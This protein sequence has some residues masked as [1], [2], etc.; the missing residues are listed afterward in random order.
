VTNSISG[1]LGNFTSKYFAVIIVIT[2][3]VTAFFTMA[4]FSLEANTTAESMNSDT[5]LYRAWQRYEDNFRPST[6]GIPVVLEAKDGNILNVEEFREIANAMNMVGEDELVKPMMIEYFDTTQ[7]VNRTILNV[8]PVEVEFVMKPNSAYGYEIG[9]HNSNHQG[10]SLANATDTD[11]NFVLDALFAHVESDGTE[12]YREI[13]SFELEKVNGQ[14]QAPV[15]M[16]FIAVDRSILEQNYT[17]DYEEKD[18]KF[19]EEF[20]L[21]VMN[22]LKS[23]IKSCNVYGVGVGV[24]DEIEREIEESGPFTMFVFIIIIIILAVTFKNNMKSFLAAAIGL[25]LIVLWM[26]GSARILYLA[27]TQF[28]AFLPILIMA[29]GV[30]YAIHSMKRFDEELV[31][32]KTPREAI[33]GSVSKLSGTLALAMITTFV[34]FISNIFSTIPALKDWGIE[35]GLAIIWTLI[36]MGLFVPA[37]RL[38]FEKGVNRDK[39]YLSTINPNK[40]EK[41]KTNRLGAGLSNLTFSS[42]RHPS[43]VIIALIILVVPLGYGAYNL[44]SEFEL[45]EFFNPE[46]DFIVG[47]DI[48]TEHFPEGGEPNIILIE[49]DVADPT[50]VEAVKISRERFDSRGYATFYSMDID[51]LIQNFTENL[52][53]NNMVRGNNITIIDNNNDNIPDQKSVIEAIY[54]HAATYGLFGFVN[55][56]VTQYTRPDY[57]IEVLHYNE[58]EG[59]FDKTIMYVGVAGSGSLENIK[60]GMDNIEKDTKV[61]EDTGKAEAIVTGSGPIRYEQLTAISN[62]M[63]NSI[64]IS[65]VLCFIILL[66]IFRKPGFAI[67]AILPVILIAIWLYGIMHFTGYHLNIV[68]ATIGAM[69]IGVGV[70]YSIHV[71]DRYRKE[72]EEG[73]EFKPAMKNTIS[74]SG[75][76][77][78]FSG[79]TTTFGFF[80]ML[81]APMPMFFSFG[82]FSGLMVLFALIASVIVVPPLIRIAER[83]KD[84]SK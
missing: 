72:R 35:A 28:T 61:I 77:L 26:L 24:N 56:N 6:H 12:I 71:C 17:Y 44:S 40:V 79:L 45:E 83:N 20:D 18:K 73:N 14:W 68:T 5:E 65:I 63:V 64:M 46:S 7:Y 62:S 21:H 36:I 41:I 25:P 66:V 38:A 8:L 32:G 54:Q 31:E 52:E 57:I 58:E 67:I 42:I 16:A 29:L 39:T 30:D 80:T 1:K 55:N 22:I 15:L 82:L 9:Y 47:L 49:G 75:A 3:L 23:N 84:K 13:V 74:N 27:E 78:V 70:D 76:A 51:E 50:V 33:K 34:A 48:Y 2:L 60:K 19:F 53:A 81:F 43:G 59:R 69:S 37:L 11:L 4:Y 10:N